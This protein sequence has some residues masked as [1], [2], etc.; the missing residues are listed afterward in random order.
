MKFSQMPYTRPD[1]DQANEKLEALLLQFQKAATTDECFAAYKAYDDF[2]RHINTMFSLAFVRNSLDT[3]D[4][5]YAAEIDYIDEI[6]PKLEEVIQKFTTAL[7]ESPYRKEMEAK[8]GTLMFVNAEIQLK[9]FKP[10]IIPDLQ[11]ENKLSTEYDKLIASAE[12]NFDGQ[13]LTL[14]Q[15]QPYYEKPDRTLR[16]AAMKAASEWYMSNAERLDSLFD[17]LVQVRTRI[18]KKLGFENFIQLGYYRM[19]RNCYDRDMVAQ[20]RQGV[21]D[22]IVP[23]TKRLKAEQAKRIRVDALKIFDDLFK[24]PDGNATP[25][26]TPED[27]FAHGQKMYKELSDE[28]AEFFD[29]MLENELFDVL[30]RPGKAAGGYCTTLDDYKSPFIFANFNGTS[31]DIDVLT[32][33]AGHA[34]ASYIA[35]DIYPTA[36]QDYSSE[37]A[38]IHSM[39]MEFFTWPWMK[40]FFGEQ[41]EKYYYSHLSDALTFIPYGTMV[42]DFQH[43]I[44]Q[45]PE[46]S[47]KQRN[48]LWLEL[49]GKYRPW[50][51]LKGFPFYGEG[52]RWQGQLH[53]YQLPFYYIDYCLAQI[54]AL[55]FW[56][57][58]QKAHEQAWAKYRRLVGFAGTKTFVELI[59]DAGLPTPFVPD[60]LKVVGDAAVA[61]LDK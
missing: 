25:Q 7:V 24:Y 29:F 21:L 15:I 10:E 12:I 18:A 48:D 17:E 40:G 28:T 11:E 41:T 19:Q 46:M 58:D 35:R 3:K 31:G 20:F 49:E 51:D 23:V 16:E 43:H 5:F 59:T 47:P 37:T 2:S 30:T 45:N 61:W 56:A 34:F 52:R 38:E 55:C 50:L 6:S 22:H 60:T 54:M 1:Y 44:Y 57:E 33:E 32:H 8:W 9:T 42:D 13:T 53:I 26:G 14:A 36:L 39:S 27:I 4:E